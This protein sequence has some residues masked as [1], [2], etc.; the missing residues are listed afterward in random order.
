QIA[1]KLLELFGLAVE[2]GENPDLGAE[3]LRHNRNRDV[4]DRA[5]LIGAQTV[6]VG[7][8]NGR[9]K[10]D[11]RVL[12]AGMLADHGGQLETVEIGHADVDEND[13]DI[14][15]EQVS[16]CFLS[17]VGLDEIFAQAVQNRFVAQKL[18]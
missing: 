11:R 15:L 16:Q 9:N 6:D 18:G 1:I 8:V 13:R 5:H 7:Q 4:I 3:H 17:T 2:L 10:D 12:E 14:L